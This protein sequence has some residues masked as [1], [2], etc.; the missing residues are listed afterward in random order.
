M[1]AVTS[2]NCFQV[3]NSEITDKRATKS[4]KQM[5]QQ[6]YIDIIVWELNQE[7]KQAKKKL[8]NIMPTNDGSFYALLPVGIT[9]REHSKSSPWD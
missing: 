9:M 1:L 4:V 2:V 7:V 3:T 6:K 8:Q 5:R